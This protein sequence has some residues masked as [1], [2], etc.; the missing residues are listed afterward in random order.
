[1]GSRTELEF[2]MELYL[3]RTYQCVRSEGFGEEIQSMQ[4]IKNKENP[5]CDETQKLVRDGRHL[6]NILAER[7]TLAMVADRIK[8]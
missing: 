6:S 2:Y 4:Q 3:L 1:M 8:V 5:W 7:L